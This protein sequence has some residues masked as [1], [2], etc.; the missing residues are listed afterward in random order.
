ML[1]SISTT[2]YTQEIARLPEHY[3]GESYINCDEAVAKLPALQGSCEVH[4]LSLGQ[5]IGMVWMEVDLRE[6]VRVLWPQTPQPPLRFWYSDTDQVIHHF[7]QDGGPPVQLSPLGAGL[8]LCQPD[9]HE[10]IELMAAQPTRLVMVELD[11]P[12]YLEQ[13]ACEAG[14]FPEDF[15]QQLQAAFPS[16]PYFHQGAY[17]I[18]LANIVR[19]IFVN[20]Y[21]AMARKAFLEAKAIEFVSNHL[22]HF[23]LEQQEQQAADTLSAYDQQQINQAA[24]IL[25]RDLVHPPRIPELARAVGLNTSKLK[26]GFKEVFGQTIGRYLREQRMRRAFQL[27]EGGATSVAE[28][29]QQVGY[30]HA[31][32]FARRFRERYGFFPNQLLR[33]V[34]PDKGSER[35]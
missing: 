17:G 4:G 34:I 24:L 19:E 35:T 12:A 20:N 25:A 15:L 31:G 10:T 11:R 3:P 27:L 9:H 30:T 18:R 26:E 33:S 1:L 5:G 7:Q 6:P 2:D 28:V 29:A 23:R 21:Q 16:S 22:H 8:S 13:L 32:H 14:A